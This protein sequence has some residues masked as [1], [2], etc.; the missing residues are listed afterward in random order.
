[1]FTHSRN[2]SFNDLRDWKVNHTNELHRLKKLDVTGNEHWLPGEQLLQLS[3]LTTVEGVRLSQ[4]CQDCYLCKMTSDDVNS[5]CSRGRWLSSP[6]DWRWPDEIQYG[7][8]LDFVKL[9]FWPRCLADHVS[10][11]DRYQLPAL[12]SVTDVTIKSS[13]ALYATGSV[14]LLVNIAVVVFIICNKSLRNDLAVRLLLNVA[15]GDA[16]IALVSILFA[17]FI[18]AQMYFKHLLDQ[19]Q[20]KDNGTTPLKRR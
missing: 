18:S 20:G 5:S 10:R 14:A 8:A 9:G 13:L 15:V 6:S 16:L 19:L 7:R 4:Y 11:I 12:T 1:M 17:R 2:V 3:N